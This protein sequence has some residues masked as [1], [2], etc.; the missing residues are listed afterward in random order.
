M[1]SSDLHEH[2][3]HLSTTEARQANRGR[4]ILLVLIASVVLTGI[5]LFA[6]WG[7][8]AGD[9]HRADANSASRVAASSQTTPPPPA[10]LTSSPQNP[11]TT[12]VNRQPSGQP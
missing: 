7:W 2:A 5:A 1:A 3:A 10:S 8:R 6:A 9:F 4:H 12:G 11:A